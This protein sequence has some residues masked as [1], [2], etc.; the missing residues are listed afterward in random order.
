MKQY[1]LQANYWYFYTNYHTKYTY[2]IYLNF[3]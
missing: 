1:I 2:Q 3:T